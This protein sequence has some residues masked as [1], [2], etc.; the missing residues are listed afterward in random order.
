[1]RSPSAATLALAV[2]ALSVASPFCL[3]AAPASKPASP[4]ATATAP[5]A[6]ARDPRA[7]YQA[8]TLAMVQGDEKAVFGLLAFVSDDAK[9]EAQ[10]IVGAGLAE[11]QWQAALDA[12]FKPPATGPSAT[13]AGDRP[14]PDLMA[15]E[16]AA[17]TQTITGYSAELKLTGRTIAAGRT[18][19]LVM[20]QGVWKIDFDKTQRAAE[21]PYNKDK[22]AAATARLLAYKDLIAQVQANKFKTRAQAQEELQKS[23][24]AIPVPRSKPGPADAAKRNGTLATIS[25]LKTAIDT[26][27]VDNGRLPREA[28][29][30]QVLLASPGGDVA[31]SW[32]GP[33]ITALPQDPWGHPYI[34]SN[35]DRFT[36]NIVSAGPDGQF[37]T[38]DDI[39]I[40][41]IR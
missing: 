41:T 25:N 17:A 40:N 21:G 5:T 38:D 34:Y 31:A 29:G 6:T 15:K 7:A 10:V 23:F 2:L 26:F 28:E 16:I 4:P 36:Y 9:N 12:A 33:Y 32:C 37:G 1:M 24:A 18:I 30:L 19:F 14:L 27:E 3:A 35:P 8:Y 22:V 11:Q 13:R 39:D 20:D